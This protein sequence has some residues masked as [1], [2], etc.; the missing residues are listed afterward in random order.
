MKRRTAVW[1]SG[2]VIT[3][4]IGLT[5]LFMTGE[6]GLSRSSQPVR[7]LDITRLN[8]E[9][10]E[11]LGWRS[12][13]LDAV[14]NHAAKL[15]T[16]SFI[17][18][19]NDEV[20]AAFGDLTE[21]YATHS[22]RKSFLSALVGRHVGSGPGQISLGA[23]LKELGI[24]DTPAPLTPKQRRA[25]VLHLLKSVS[26]VNHPAAA[27]GGLRAD[28]D[29]RLGH[30]ENEPGTIW[31]YSNWDYNALT[32]IFEKRTGMGIAQAFQEG[33]AGPTGMEDFD[34]AAVSYVADADVSMH[35]A[36]A[37]RMS[38]RDL[39]R[40]GQL[41]LNKGRIDDR[42]VLPESWIDRPANDFT[43]TGMNG[44]R[45]GHGYLWWIPGPDTGLPEG[46][47]WAWGLGNQALF[48][49]PAWDTVIVHQSDTTEFLKRFL[50]LIEN[51]GM[52]GE[53]AILQ[54][55]LSCREPENRSSTFCVEHRFVSR[56]EF[57]KLMSLVAKARL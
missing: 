49:V 36:A 56:P 28:I 55:V 38:A 23:T 1:T 3:V 44:L 14:L 24:D 51:D 11:S 40:F 34:I 48:V 43:E 30:V 53:A 9:K 15:S 13:E 6:R 17:I 4:A 46:T 22:M 52:E 19:T 50:P 26:G 39:V 33:I 2:L 35:K 27:S 21:P 18:V 5:Y 37:F 10:A 54:L 32:T 47:V 12:D 16:D 7:P 41:Y 45:R 25:T 20:V 42:Q 31:A 8:E 29:N 57:D